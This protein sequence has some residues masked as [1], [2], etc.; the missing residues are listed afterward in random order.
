MGFCSQRAHLGPSVL[1][2]TKAVGLICNSM[3]T[4]V[5]VV[6]PPLNL[7]R[8][9]RLPARRPSARLRIYSLS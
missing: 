3:W 6:R 8:A 1:H 2:E 7:R 5:R 4:V 9:P